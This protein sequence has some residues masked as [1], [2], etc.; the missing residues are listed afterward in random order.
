MELD[1]I[2]DHGRRVVRDA[3]DDGL[4]ARVDGCRQVCLDAF[5]TTDFR[6]SRTFTLRNSR[7]T[8]EPIL[9]VFN[10]FNADNYDLPGNRLTGSLTGS[11]GSLNGT[12]DANRTNRAEATGSFTP[13]APRSWQVGVRVSF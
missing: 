13:G 11:A 8:I 4:M 1:R 5:F 12:T 2:A 3:L 9:E 6:I 7:V 10:V